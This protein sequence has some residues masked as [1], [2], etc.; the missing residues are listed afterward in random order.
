MRW[1]LASRVGASD[2]DTPFAVRFNATAFPAAEIV[3]LMTLS[4][5]L[6]VPLTEAEI[7]T[8]ESREKFVVTESTN[9]EAKRLFAT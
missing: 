9:I 4:V 5:C 2:P 8:K 3:S 7:F 1:T 6:P